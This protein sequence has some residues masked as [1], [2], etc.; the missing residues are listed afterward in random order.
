MLLAKLP[1][2]RIGQVNWSA[3]AN[4]L[5]MNLVSFQKIFEV[6]SQ[7]FFG[8]FQTLLTQNQTNHFRKPFDPNQVANGI[9]E[10][11]RKKCE[12][13]AR[14]H[15][16]SPIGLLKRLAVNSSPNGTRGKSAPKANILVHSLSIC[17]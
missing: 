6:F 9:A 4:D 15:W 8:T 12:H 14:I 7:L 3:V 17:K 5:L 16:R 2:N 1:T 13:T 10:Q 11:I